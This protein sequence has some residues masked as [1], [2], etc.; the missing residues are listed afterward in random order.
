[1]S[2][3]LVAL[4]L[5]EYIQVPIAPSLVKLFSGEVL[6]EV[7]AVHSMKLAISWIVH[8]RSRVVTAMSATSLPAAYSSAT[9]TSSLGV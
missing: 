4:A 3:V 1:M 6:P 8:V 2:G 5:V 9:A 7:G